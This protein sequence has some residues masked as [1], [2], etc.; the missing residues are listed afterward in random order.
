MEAEMKSLKQADGTP[1][2]SAGPLPGISGGKPAEKSLF[3]GMRNGRGFVGVGLLLV[4]ALLLVLRMQRSLDGAPSVDDSWDVQVERAEMEKLVGD[5]LRDKALLVKD[6][7]GVGGVGSK[8]NSTAVSREK[9]M[10]R[11]LATVQRMLGKVQ[12]KQKQKKQLGNHYDRSNELS[13]Q[14]QEL[15]SELKTLREQIARLR[16]STKV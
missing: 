9:A 2:G 8:G 16:N 3:A 7:R 10:D 6:K 15:A 5:L 12:Q 13:K 1:G 4:V 11:H 14:N